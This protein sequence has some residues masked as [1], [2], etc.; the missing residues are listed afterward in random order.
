MTAALWFGSTLKDLY[1]IEAKDNI[2]GSPTASAANL[3]NDFLDRVVDHSPKPLKSDHRSIWP[4]P[5]RLK[6]LGDL[7]GR[8]LRRISPASRDEANALRLSRL[9]V[10]WPLRQVPGEP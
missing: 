4:Q 2:A 1:G 6:A 7:H 9:P 3:L 5:R 8:D 10:R